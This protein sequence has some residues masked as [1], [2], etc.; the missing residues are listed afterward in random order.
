MLHKGCWGPMAARSLVPVISGAVS[1]FQPPSLVS[2]GFIPLKPAAD[3]LTLNGAGPEVTESQHSSPQ[4]ER[5]RRRDEEAFALLV[6]EHQALVLALGQSLG[7]AG[8]DLEEAVAEAFASVYL[9]LPRFRGRSLLRTWVYRVALRTLARYRRR[10]RRRPSAELHEGLAAESD[11]AP[12]QRLELEDE[13]RRLWDAVASLD[14]RQ[15]AVI[16]LH[17]RQGWPLEEIAQA[18][19]SPV[20]TVKTHLFRGRQRLRELLEKERRT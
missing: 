14:P 17:Y 19:G 11:E 6:R 8:A 20:G 15:A 12:G 10:L 1:H 9:A 13:N 7:L 2:S 3:I 16:E 5:L 18:V 4:L